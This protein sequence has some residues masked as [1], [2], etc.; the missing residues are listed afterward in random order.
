MMLYAFD[1]GE[2]AGDGMEGFLS[3]YTGRINQSMDYERK[4]MHN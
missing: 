1:T 2:E 3:D 4:A